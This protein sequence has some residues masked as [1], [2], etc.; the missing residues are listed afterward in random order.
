MMPL[1]T[2]VGFRV[3][4]NDNSNLLPSMLDEVHHDEPDNL[5]TLIP[6]NTA[7]NIHKGSAALPTGKSLVISVNKFTYFNWVHG[8]NLLSFMK[9]Y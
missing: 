5:S 1:A 4:P 2:V 7:M 3:H 9:E 6:D 8:Q